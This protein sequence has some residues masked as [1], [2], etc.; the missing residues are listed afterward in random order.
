[1]LSRLNQFQSPRAA[2]SPRLPRGSPL[3]PRVSWSRGA[4]PRAPARSLALSTHQVKSLPF[5]LRSRPATVA[6]AP[7]ACGGGAHRPAGGETPSIGAPAVPG[8]RNP[9]KCRGPEDRRRRLWAGGARLLRPR[10]RARPVLSPAS[11]AG[12]FCGKSLTVN[13]LGPDQNTFADY[14]LAPPR[15]QREKGRF[16]IFRLSCRASVLGDTQSAFQVFM[17][18]Y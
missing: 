6:P 17:V 8:A 12:S 4:A 2:T 9:P 15:E 1:M 3:Q 10:S 11:R 14:N 18:P 13:P 7:C 5:I 16:F